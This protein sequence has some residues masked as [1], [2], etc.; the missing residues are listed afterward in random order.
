MPAPN[1]PKYGTSLAVCRWRVKDNEG[2]SPIFVS[3]RETI[4]L[5]I[6]SSVSLAA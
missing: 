5:C 3:P 4:L 1:A 2:N 6:P